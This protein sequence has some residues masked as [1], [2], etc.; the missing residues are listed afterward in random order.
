M[1]FVDAVACWGKCPVAMVRNKK[2]YI[3]TVSRGEARTLQAPGSRFS[4]RIPQ[5]SNGL[6]VTRVHTDHPIL[7]NNIPSDECIISA[8][9]EVRKVGQNGNG[10]DGLHELRLP[11]CVPDKELWKYLKVR[12]WKM[13]K[14]NSQPEELEQRE[15]KGGDGDYF[16]M[17][18][19][20]T[21]IYTGHFC[22][23]TATICEKASCKSE[24]RVCLFG[25]LWKGNKSITKLEISS[26][27]CSRLLSIEEFRDVNSF[28]LNLVR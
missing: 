24:V 1:F 5:G 27:F 8:L 14:G 18:E 6:Y 17:D 12:K 4:L 22:E 25:K 16:V 10:R 21:T 26:F 3:A 28:I 9:L 2:K 20:Y 15:V 13:V 19:K 11:H 7:R 23:T